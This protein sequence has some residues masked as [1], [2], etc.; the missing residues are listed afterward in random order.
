MSHCVD[1]SKTTL[2]F[3]TKPEMIDTQVSCLLSSNL[4]C[5]STTYF[6]MIIYP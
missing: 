2:M 3:A 1:L 5:H 6:I 4:S